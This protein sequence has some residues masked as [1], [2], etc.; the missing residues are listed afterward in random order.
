MFDLLLTRDHDL[1]IS[2]QGDIMLTQ[3]IRQAIRVRLLWFFQEWRFA[4]PI[5]VPYFEEFFTKNPN[6]VRMR[7]IIRREVKSVDGVIN[8]TNI[9]I[10][11]N[12]VTRLGLITF[13]ASTTEGDYLLEVSIPWGSTD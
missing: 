6:Q 9:R 3:S 10:N 5:G 11:I 8:V 13:T 1:F 2:Q 7:N 12:P 4:P